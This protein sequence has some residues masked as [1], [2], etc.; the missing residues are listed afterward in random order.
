MGFW[1]ALFGGPEK[2]PGEVKD[3]DAERKFDLYK[4]DG[5]K[6]LQMRQ[7]EYAVKCFGEA[8]KI[9]PDVETLDYMSQA[10]VRMGRFEEALASL[11]VVRKLLPRSEQVLRRMGHIAYMAEDYDRLAL[12]ASQAVELNEQDGY[13]CLMA[14]Q[15][16][17][18]QGRPEEAAGW[19]DR[20][21]ALD[22]SLRDARLL[23]A[24]LLTAQGDLRAAEADVQQLLDAQGDDEDALLLRAR[25]CA[26]QGRVE[27]AR[28]AYVALTEANPFCEEAIQELERL[29][30]L[31]I[32][33]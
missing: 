24:R 32:E 31:N 8:L 4:Y 30:L 3:D 11:E 9:R 23:R 6:A 26:R 18:G 29:N 20:A 14:A 2:E 15:A 28:A 12:L 27:E 19:L 5:I 1:K 22:D 21:L 7:T 25:L 33:H 10:L 13:A 16:A 17:Q